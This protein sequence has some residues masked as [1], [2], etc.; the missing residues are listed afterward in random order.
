MDARRLLFVTAL[1][2]L[3]PRARGQEAAQEGPPVPL[4]SAVRGS[5]TPAMGP[6]RRIHFRLKAPEATRVE[7]HCKGSLWG[8]KPFALAK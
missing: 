8:G 6:D 3:G 1:A 4:P 7:I 5:A 2:L